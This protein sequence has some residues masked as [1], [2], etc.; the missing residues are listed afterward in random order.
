MEIAD[1]IPAARLRVVHDSGHLSTVEQPELVTGALVDW[2][3]GPT[4]G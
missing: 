1:G 3:A 4:A 2:L